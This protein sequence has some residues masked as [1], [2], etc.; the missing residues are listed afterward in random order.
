MS[1]RH[2]A[3]RQQ[4]CADFLVAST[5]TAG[6]R[7]LRAGVRPHQ[8]ADREHPQEAKKAS[9]LPQ[10]LGPPLSERRATRPQIG[11]RRSTSLC[12]RLQPSAERVRLP[13]SCVEGGV[14]RVSSTSS[15]S[16]ADQRGRAACGKSCDARGRVCVPGSD[17]VI[18]ACIPRTDLAGLGQIGRVPLK[19]WRSADWPDFP[20]A[21]AHF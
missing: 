12:V 1:V 15:P 11:L 19:N 20:P 21:T 9:P 2:W 5:S 6:S 16:E 7:A 13:G 3:S 18:Q 8:G 4:G 14:R 17:L 10:R